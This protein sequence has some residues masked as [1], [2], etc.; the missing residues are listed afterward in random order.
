MNMGIKWVTSMTFTFSVS[1]A[2]WGRIAPEL[3]LAGIALLLLLADLLLPRPAK[4]SNASGKLIISPVLGLPTKSFGRSGNYLILPALSLLGLAGAFAA[5]IILFLVGDQQSAFNSMVGS[6]FGS[7]YAY[8]II[9]SASML[10]IWLSPAYLTRWTRA[11][12]G[13]YY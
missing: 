6:D 11:H 2:D 13:E 4:N 9:L 10:G 7:L 1:A 12:E 3:V 8:I 5:T